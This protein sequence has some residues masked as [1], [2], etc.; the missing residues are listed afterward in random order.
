MMRGV[1]YLF[2]TPRISEIR[3]DMFDEAPQTAHPESHKRVGRPTRGVPDSPD[4]IVSGPRL[5]SGS[6]PAQGG[7]SRPV[8]CQG[9]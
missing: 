5:G 2:S 9:Q 1:E 3:L 6:Q 7:C 4:R 8:S